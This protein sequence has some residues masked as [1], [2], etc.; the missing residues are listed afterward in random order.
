MFCIIEDSIVTSFSLGV[1]SVEGVDDLISG[2]AIVV[3]IVSGASVEVAV[4]VAATV[5]VATADVAM[6]RVSDISFIA[7]AFIILYGLLLFPRKDFGRY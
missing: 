4:A 7:V 2:E 5:A 1:Y 6:G 3:I